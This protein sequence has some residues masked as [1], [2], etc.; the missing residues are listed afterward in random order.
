MECAH[1]A[2]SIWSR[3][4][5]KLKTKKEEKWRRP[6]TTEYYLAEAEQVYNITQ[7]VEFQIKDK[8]I[9]VCATPL[10]KQ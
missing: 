3:T 8:L 2:Y 4:K 7:N 5:K 6:N 9:F 10:K 1:T